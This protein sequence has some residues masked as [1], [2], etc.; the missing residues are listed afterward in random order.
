ME[1]KLEEAVAVLERTPNVIAALLTGLPERWLSGNEGPDSF[2]P[3]DVVGHLLSGEETDWIPRIEI[4]MKE[5]T[6]RPFTPFD[7]FSFREKYREL[8]LE[9]LLVRFREIR[10]RNLARLKELSI[11]PEDLAREGS[12]PDLGAVTMRQLLATW[13]VHDM[14]HLRQIARVMAK[15]Y[16][17]QVG[18][19]ERYLRVLQE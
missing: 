16:R 9:E 8:S 1:L 14:S 18:P 13:A 15:Q 10:A 11:S 6:S 4:I 2:N 7:R 17:D 19:W 12:H 3:R 5:G